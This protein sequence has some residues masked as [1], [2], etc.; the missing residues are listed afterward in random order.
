MEKAAEKYSELNVR[1]LVI[2]IILAFIAGVT[3]VLLTTFY[4]YHQVQRIATINS[5]LDEITSVCRNQNTLSQFVTKNVLLLKSDSV[6]DN[7]NIHLL[8]SS[9]T[10]FQLNHQVIETS[11]RRLDSSGLDIFKIDSIYVH[12]QVKS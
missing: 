12:N 2:K 6:F 11:N 4:A 7:E 9:L 10:L 3:V 5:E 1:K 8:D